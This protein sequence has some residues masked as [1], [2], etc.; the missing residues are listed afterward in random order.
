MLE[1]LRLAIWK[2]TTRTGETQG[3]I[4]LKAQI[5]ETRL[6]LMIRGKVEP[7]KEERKAL[8]AVLGIPEKDLFAIG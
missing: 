7:T 1:N 3:K 8:S 5:V 6:S 4:G 2:R